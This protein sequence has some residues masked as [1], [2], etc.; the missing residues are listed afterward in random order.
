MK[1]TVLIVCP[2]ES[3][4]FVQQDAAILSTRFGVKVLSLH[5]LRNPKFFWTGVAVAGAL[6]SGDIAAILMWFSVPH[7]APVIVLLAGLF[8]KKVIAITGGFDVAYVPAIKWGEMGKRWKRILQRFALRRV[9]ACLPFSD[10]SKTDTL[11]YARTGTV[12]T[13]YPGIDTAHFSPGGEK[14]DTVVTTCNIINASTI[15]QK[16]LDVFV[17]CAAALPDLRFIIVG[18]MSAADPA[19][20]KFRECAPPNVTFTERYVSDEELLSIYRRA[21]VYVQTSAHEGF[22]I[23]CAEAMACECVPVGTLG[24]SLPEVIGDAG[25]LVAYRDVPGTV[26][27]IREAVVN[28][29]LRAKARKRVVEKFS[30]VE[31]SA[32]LIGAFEV[33]LG[34]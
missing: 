19:S 4:S 8:R 10:F 28:D 30:P 14:G 27:A 23:A 3:S 31:R 15:V 2:Q 21:R 17:E 25:F 1:K 24:T 22:G 18:E 5:R 34:G 7:L 29:A 20:V 12:S 33:I 9:D 13:I 11:R 6:G 26:K 32:K 16:G